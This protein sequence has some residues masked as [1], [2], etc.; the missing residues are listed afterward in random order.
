M[1][2]VKRTKRIFHFQLRGYRPSERT[3]F[4]VTAVNCPQAYRIVRDRIGSRGMMGDIWYRNSS[5][6]WVS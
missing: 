5:G 2:K 6:K 1:T 3:D 4:K